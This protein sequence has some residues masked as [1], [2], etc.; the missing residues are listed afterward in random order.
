MAVIPMKRILVVIAVLGLAASLGAQSLVELAKRE[1][2]RREGLKGRH[3]AVVTNRDLL[4]VK[5]LPAVEVSLP[6]GGFDDTLSL[7]SEPGQEQ[8][9]AGPGADGMAA[10][11]EVAEGGGT[12][13]D[14]LR[15]VD[16]VVDNLTL[17]MNALR[18][19]FEAQNTMVPGSVIQQQMEETNQRLEQAKT[20]QAG[21]RA[22]MER[23]GIP[24]KKAAEPEIR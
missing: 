19:Q 18:Q 9:P 4:L 24:V 3:A 5:K 2:E 14:Q 20:R 10:T 22:K 23:Q 11:G 8:P 16:E 15:V 12:L 1:K 17:E 13:E 7:G 21:I 6:P